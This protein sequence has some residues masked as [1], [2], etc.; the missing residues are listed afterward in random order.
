MTDT[1]T[2]PAPGPGFNLTEEVENKLEELAKLIVTEV[3]AKRAA[4]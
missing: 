2:K 1:R 4:P 3:K